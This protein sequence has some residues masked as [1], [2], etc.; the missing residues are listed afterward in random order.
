M[1]RHNISSSIAL[2]N[3]VAF[4]GWKDK[5][6]LQNLL[7]LMIVAVQCKVVWHSVNSKLRLH[8]CN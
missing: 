4:P 3:C 7:R 6:Y 1:V 5:N 2:H 8:V